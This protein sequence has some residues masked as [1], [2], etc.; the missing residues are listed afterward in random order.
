[1]KEAD[2]VFSCSS[3]RKPLVVEGALAGKRVNC[4]LCGEYIPVPVAKPGILRGSRNSPAAMVSRQMRQLKRVGSQLS[5]LEESFLSAER[6]MPEME[7]NLQQMIAEAKLMR[8]ELQLVRE[9]MGTETPATF[10]EAQ[11]ADPAASKDEGDEGWPWHWVAYG[12]SALF[13][14]LLLLF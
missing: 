5:V 3:C 9:Q 14:L 7:Q 4:P 6:G 8:Q 1:M 12:L 13:A 10:Q 11:Q 2:I